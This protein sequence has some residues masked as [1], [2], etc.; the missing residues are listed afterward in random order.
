[1]LEADPEKSICIASAQYINSKNR[2]GFMSDGTEWG[3]L[4]ANDNWKLPI[5]ASYE[6]FFRSEQSTWKL[7]FSVVSTQL[8]ASSGAL[9]DEFIRDLSKTRNLKLFK[10]DK[11][12]MGSFSMDG[13]SRAITAAA[14]C[15]HR[16][17]AAKPKVNPTNPFETIKDNPFG[18]TE[19][20]I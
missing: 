12:L 14:E 19:K 18:G 3:L 4:L 17:S 10:S 6:M 11:S 7:Q 2:F 5:G 8:M 9:K 20:R 13:S 1:L 15:A 16:L